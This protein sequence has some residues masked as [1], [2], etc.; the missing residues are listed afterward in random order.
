MPSQSGHRAHDGQTAAQAHQ[1]APYPLTPPTS[2]NDSPEPDPP[3]SRPDVCPPLFRIR[4]TRSG[5]HPCSYEEGK[6]FSYAGLA[7]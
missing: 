5:A 6:S 4:R 7:L 3:D 1:F 2:S